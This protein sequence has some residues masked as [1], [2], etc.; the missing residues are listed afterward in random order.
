MKHSFIPLFALVCAVSAYEEQDFPNLM[1]PTNLSPGNLV[2]SVQHRFYGRIDDGGRLFFG[3]ANSVSPSFGLRYDLW[4]TLEANAAFYAADKEVEVGA[5]CAFLYPT[6][7]LKAQVE[8]EYYD[9]SAF[10]ADNKEFRKH[11]GCVLF[12]LQSYPIIQS[13]SPAVN[14]GYDFDRRKWGLGLG[15]NVTLVE[16]LD[17]FGEYFPLLEKNK[18]STALA[19]K[20]VFSFGL[21]ISTAGHHFLFFLQNSVDN[22]AIGTIGSRH[23]M[24][25]SDNNNLHFGFE[26][27]RLFAF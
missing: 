4:R 12:A 14:A 19:T 6:I 16:G 26:I 21:K 18:D 2:A 22:P 13:I 5:S 24:F 8:G 10:D 25:G 23:V 17:V 1:A 20:N 11:A 3:F 15:L 27:E 7:Y 9:F